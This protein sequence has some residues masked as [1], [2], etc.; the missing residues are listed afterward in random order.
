MKS[1]KLTGILAVCGFGALAFFLVI[2]CGAC[3]HV[4]AADTIT[5][6]EAKDRVGTV[7][8]VRGVVASTAYSAKSKG[9]PTFLN[10]DKP[11]PNAIFTIVIWGEDRAKFAPLPE[12]QYRDK[13]ISVTGPITTHKDKNGKD[14]PQIEVHDPKQIVIEDPPK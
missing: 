14:T 11:Y 3:G 1:E 9:K 6:A 12:N 13:T 4:N 10:L 5:A 7:Q 2:A 8:T